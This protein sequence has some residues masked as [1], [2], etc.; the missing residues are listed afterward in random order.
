MCKRKLKIKNLLCQALF[1][2]YIIYGFTACDDNSKRYEGKSYDPSVPVTVS[3]FFPDSGK[4]REKVIL[5]GVNF[6]S[7]PSN[8][9]VYF[10]NK[11]A[12][13]VGS[14]GER[15]Y[16]IVPR[17]PGDTCTVTVAVGEGN[18][19]G[20][21]SVVY[22]HKFRYFVT[23]S[24]STV[25]GDGTGTNRPGALQQAQIAPFQLDVDAN[26]NIFVGVE[27]GFVGGSNV[28]DVGFVRINEAENIMELIMNLGNSGASSA[29]V[30][31]PRFEGISCDKFTGKLYTTINANVFSYVVIDP[32]ENWV[33]R[34]KTFHWVTNPLHPE[35]DQ[36]RPTSSG[37]YMAYNQ[38]DKHLYTRFSAGQIV[39]INENTG[40]GMIIYRTPQQNG[41]SIGVDIDPKHPNM[42]YIAGY[43]AT[44][45]AHGI[46]RLDLND[47]D[48]SWERLNTT[49]A[50]GH[51]DGPISQAMFN[52][53]Y[54]LRFD[55]DGIAYISDLNNNCI[56]R[57]DP[58][59]GIV[60]TVL[61]IPGQS[62]FKD[63]GR[64][65]ALFNQPSAVGVDLDGNV[66]VADR[67]NRRIRKLAIE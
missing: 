52:T 28:K 2:T 9:R 53:P 45:I 58:E 47:P 55:M 59:T 36:Q 62:G 51:K 30:Q 7:D 6:G 11:R 23:V 16:A 4:I 15:M 43:N 25:C 65:D 20:F 57:F 31:G 22:E 42:M 29:T 49:T 46:Y 67:A 35:Y 17:M 40:E 26:G 24:V 38:F 1:S 19:L 33:P 27:L 50:S 60:S 41:T 13:V 3:S 5:D 18:K 10:N 64:E 39:K 54:G 66:Y 44:G 21:D 61:G 48:N 14:T 12:T 63:G 34:Y 56:R 8:I 37:N 32:A